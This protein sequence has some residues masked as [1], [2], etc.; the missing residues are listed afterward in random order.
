MGEHSV[1]DALAPSM[2]GEYM[3]QEA[4][5]ESAFPP[6]EGVVARSRSSEAGLAG[7]WERLVFDTDDCILQACVAAEDRAKAL[8]F[9][10]DAAMFYFKNY[11]SDWIKHVGKLVNFIITKKRY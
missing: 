2:F 8:I 5:G 6:I 10:S 9:D 1:C 7:G 4:I 3:V 11:G